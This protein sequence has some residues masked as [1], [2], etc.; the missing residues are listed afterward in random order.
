MGVSRQERTDLVT[1]GP[2]GFLGRRLVSVPGT[3][4][5]L[6]IVLPG[7]IL[8]ALAELISIGIDGVFGHPSGRRSGLRHSKD[9]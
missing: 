7:L 4:S 3:H 8:D 5:K 6:R 9:A 2:Y 1:H